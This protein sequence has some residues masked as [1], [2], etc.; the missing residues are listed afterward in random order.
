MTDSAARREEIAAGLAAT[1]DRL[2][3]AC[4]AASRPRDAVELVV[5]TKTFP[6]SDVTILASLGVVEVAENR[7]Q[8]ARAKAAELAGLP[9]RWQMIGQVQRNKAASVARWAHVVCSVD[10]LPLVTALAQG[11][12]AAGRPLDCLVQVCLD[13]VPGRGGVMP[14]ELA[15]LCDAVAAEESLRLRGLMAVAPHPGDPEEAFERLSRLR[16]A[17]LA[18]HPSATTLS[19]GMSGDLEEAVRHGATQVRI[20]SAI[21]G[22]RPVVA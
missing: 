12:Q 21:L 8:E 1:R 6:A 11:A 9:L 2:E 19:A 18:A 15:A 5:V 22:T 20:G 17:V 3:A 14:A 10:R 7:D 13:P 16:E 4:I